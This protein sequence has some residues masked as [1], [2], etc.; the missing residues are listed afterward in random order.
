MTINFTFAT[1]LLLLNPYQT[2]CIDW[3]L[4]IVNKYF[5]YR[6]WFVVVVK[7]SVF[8]LS[9]LKFGNLGIK[10]IIG[11]LLARCKLALAVGDFLDDGLALVGLVVG[12]TLFV[13]DFFGV[14]FWAV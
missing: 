8:E 2:K 12:L 6:C 13:A 4:G 11:C 10:F 7:L 5:A 9:V 3:H 14:I 1:L